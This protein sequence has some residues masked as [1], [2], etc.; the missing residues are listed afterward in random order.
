MVALAAVSRSLAR[1]HMLA[2]A[3]AAV[4]Y[5][6]DIARF[7]LETGKARPGQKRA[8]GQDRYPRYPQAMSLA[9]FH[10]TLLLLGSPRVSVN[11]Y[12]LLSL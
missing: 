10:R 1:H 7:F 11:P 8:K 5:H 9:A 12:S 6:G 3:L 4:L 2:V